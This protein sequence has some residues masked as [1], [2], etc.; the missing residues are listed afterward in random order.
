MT[1]VGGAWYA[2]AELMGRSA[3]KRSFMARA[4]EVNV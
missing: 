4:G 1:L 3:I 2:R